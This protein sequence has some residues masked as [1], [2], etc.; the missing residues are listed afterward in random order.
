[1]HQTLTFAR[2]ESCLLYSVVFG[3]FWPPHVRLPMLLC[4]HKDMEVALGF[5]NS[6]ITTAGPRNSSI[7]KNNWLAG[8]AL[9]RRGFRQSAG[10]MEAVPRWDKKDWVGLKKVENL[11]RFPGRLA[12]GV[13]P[14]WQ[15]GPSIA[16][17]PQD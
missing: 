11:F 17:N 16:P 9:N 15:A 4:W 3:F 1:M 12:C 2:F 10:G 13:P 14:G 8:N 6:L 5:C 7:L